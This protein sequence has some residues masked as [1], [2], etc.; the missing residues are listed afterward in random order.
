MNKKLKILV[1]LNCISYIVMEFI[2]YAIRN[3]IKLDNKIKFIVGSI[4]WLLIMSTSFIL[5][6]D[7]NNEFQSVKRE[8][9]LDWL[10]RIIAFGVVFNYSKQFNNIF[11]VFIFII[12]T[13]IANTV[14]EYR[15][16]K[17]IMNA[18]DRITKE[19]NVEITYEE[20]CNLRAMVK[21]I[22]LGMFS[23]I[24]FSGAALS[25]PITK[26]MEGTTMW[27][28]P[29]IISIVVFIWFIKTTYNNYFA[30]Y[31][32]KKYVKK[33]FSR[34]IVFAS[35]GYGICLIS[36]FLHFENSAFAYVTIVGILF[37]LPTIGTVRK[38]SL[39][40]KVIKNNLDRD[41]FRYF[42]TKTEE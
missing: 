22:N 19:M 41:T 28:I 32:D 27:Y 33:V 24:V 10:T 39:R 34:D 2:A 35:I 29:I 3:D 42:L 30:F 5:A 1:V 11:L 8:A 9:I 38:M 12:A 31:L 20:K 26:N 21:A 17:K 18:R 37:L 36:S 25:V 4:P 7:R 23:I 16:N 15:I 6:G 40:L 14:I 13:F